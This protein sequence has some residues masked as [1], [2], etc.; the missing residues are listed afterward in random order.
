M[1]ILIASSA[2]ALAIA[3]TGATGSLAAG[4]KNTAGKFCWQDQT[5]ANK[6]DCS[7]AT[8]NECTSKHQTGCVASSETTGMGGMNKNTSG[9]AN[10]SNGLNSNSMSGGAS[11]PSSSGK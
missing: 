8:M 9:S 3:L 1:R 10:P 11:K 2:L 5:S 6:P 7:Y 4:A